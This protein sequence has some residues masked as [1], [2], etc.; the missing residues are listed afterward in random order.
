MKCSYC[1]WR[2]ELR[3]DSLGICRMYSLDHGKIQERFPNRWSYSVSRVESLPFYHA[4]PGSRS[5]TIGTSGC[6]FSCRYCSN[7]HIALHDPDTL[8]EHTYTMTPE[9]LVGMGQKLNCHNIVFNVNEPTVSLPALVKLKEVA[10][11]AGLPMGCLTNAYGTM[12]S[13][14]LLASIFDFIN[15]GLKGFTSR[16]YR[17]FIGVKNIGPILRNIRRLAVLRH[18]EVTTPVIQNVNDGQLDVIAEFLAD[19]NPEIPWH[20]FRLLPEYEMKSAEYP[21]IERIGHA[22]ESARKKLRYVY[23]HNFVGSEWV[24]TACP[25]CGM[26]VIERLSLGC[27]GDKLDDFR[28]LGNQ[29]PRCGY[30]IKIHGQYVPP[31][32]ERRVSA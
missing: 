4:H 11:R 14:E 26:E 31:L 22:L 29:C 30:E 20:I 15:I 13:T 1:E 21:N 24:N 28:C 27:G 3:E 8:S 18:V 12:E 7:A 2:C 17:E 32:K 16:F 5:L 6:N 19:I 10:D 9:E 23:F 25:Q